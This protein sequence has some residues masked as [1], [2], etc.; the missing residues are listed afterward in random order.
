[1]MRESYEKR[2]QIYEPRF[3]QVVEGARLQCQQK[4]RTSNVFLSE[5]RV[6]FLF[7]GNQILIALLKTGSFRSLYTISIQTDA[8]EY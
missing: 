3:L 6:F 8:Q 2:N 1:M 4:N 5:N 7:Q